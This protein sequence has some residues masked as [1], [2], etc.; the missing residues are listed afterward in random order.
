MMEPPKHDIDFSHGCLAYA[1][2]DIF[3]AEPKE[4]WTAVKLAVRLETFPFRHRSLTDP[5]KQRTRR[6]QSISQ[7]LHKLALAGRIALVRKPREGQPCKYATIGASCSIC[8][9]YPCRCH[10]LEGKR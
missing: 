10:A 1:I 5:A 3:A 2:E 9:E 6:I 7:S 4:L 8:S